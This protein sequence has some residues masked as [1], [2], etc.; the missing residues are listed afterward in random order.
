MREYGRNRYHNMSEEKRKN[1]K[2]IKE[3]IGKLKSFDL[4]INI[5]YG[6]KNVYFA[7]VITVKSITFMYF[8]LT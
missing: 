7:L 8:R 3:I 2:N 1:L 6:L 4:E 5:I